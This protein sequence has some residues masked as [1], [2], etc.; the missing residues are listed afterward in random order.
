M[1]ISTFS[2]SANSNEIDVIKK[3][4]DSSK[5]AYVEVDDKYDEYMIKIDFEKPYDSV[6]IL[7]AKGFESKPFKIKLVD[8]DNVNMVIPTTSYAF[9]NV[10]FEN[11]KDLKIDNPV[12]SGGQSYIKYFHIINCQKAKFVGQSNTDPIEVKESVSLSGSSIDYGVKTIVDKLIAS[13]SGVYQLPNLQTK[14]LTVSE[15]AEIAEITIIESISVESSHLT[16]NNC[17]LKENVQIQIKKSQRKWPS[18]SI[19]NT[20]IKSTIVNADLGFTSS[21]S[22][23]LDDKYEGHVLISGFSSDDI[24]CNDFLSKV[25]LSN[26]GGFEKRCSQDGQSLLA[27]KG[28]EQTFDKVTDD[29]NKP[30][31]NNKPNDT[32]SNEPNDNPIK[33]PD[34]KPFPVGGI[35]GIVVGVIVVIAVVVVVVIFILKKKKNDVESVDEINNDDDMSTGL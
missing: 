16:L 11:F 29:D 15:T 3:T 12:T 9:I 26:N 22:R 24:S 33:N 35:I 21:N 5:Y 8:R 10:Y 7:P 27:A 17:D 23:L 28:E 18:I 31:D 20:P 32:N 4:G 1:F 13:E 19:V 6:T 34:N 25:T 30:D 14:T 2:S